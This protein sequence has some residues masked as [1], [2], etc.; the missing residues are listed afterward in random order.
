[1]TFVRSSDPGSRSAGSNDGPPF[2][3]VPPELWTVDNNLKVAN[4]SWPTACTYPPLPRWSPR[5]RYC[6]D[7]PLR[8]AETPAKT[9]QARA[10]PGLRS[11]P[12]LAGPPVTSNSLDHSPADHDWTT[13][14]LRV[15]R[16]MAGPQRTRRPRPSRPTGLAVI[17]GISHWI[18]DAP[19]MGQLNLQG[20]E[21]GQLIDDWSSGRKTGEDPLDAWRR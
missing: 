20:A 1:M 10:S 11:R 13:T 3:C 2:R 18:P 19:V 17:A 5:Q 15:P 4:I 16:G 12:G 6:S 9:S 7:V 14:G 21:A 8:F